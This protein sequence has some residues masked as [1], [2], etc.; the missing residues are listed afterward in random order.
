MFQSC[1]LQ[2]FVLISITFKFFTQLLKQL[3]LCSAGGYKDV[4]CLKVF[5]YRD[6]PSKYAAGRHE[7]F[8]LLIR[9]LADALNATLQ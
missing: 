2:Q 7:G 4:V 3:Y 6:P 8:R 1:G 5:S 9:S